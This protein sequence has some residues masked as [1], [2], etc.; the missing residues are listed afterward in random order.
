MIFFR[1]RMMFFR[2]RMVFFKRRMIFF[3]R[4]VLF[5]R[6][7]DG[8]FLYIINLDYLLQLIFHLSVIVCL[9]L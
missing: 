1:K 8:I 7:E 5:R 4:T 2:K 9:K 3:R 6:K